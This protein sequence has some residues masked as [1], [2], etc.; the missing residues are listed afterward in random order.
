MVAE[1][2]LTPSQEPEAACAVP[3]NIDAEQAILG[4]LLYENA[5]YHRIADWLKSEHFHDPVHARIFEAIGDQIGIGN[6]C[7]PI[8]LKAKLE[9]DDGLVQIGGTAYLVELVQSAPLTSNAAVEYGR[10]V[11]ELALRRALIRVSDEMGYAARRDSDD[12]AAELIEE[13]EA[14]LAALTDTEEG[15]T[16]CSAGQALRAALD[17][18]LTFIETGLSGFDDMRTIAPAL[19][20]VGARSSM[21]KSAIV[22]DQVLRSARNG[23]PS[24]MLTN[25]MTARQIAAR[26]AASMTGVPYFAITNGTMHQDQRDQVAQCIAEIEALPITIIECPGSGIP[27]LRSRIRRWLRKIEKAG[28]EPGVVGLDYLQNISGQGGSLYERTSDIALGLQTVQLTFGICLL[29]ACQLARAAEHEK[30]KRPSIR[31]LRDSGK[32]EEVADKILLVY[33]DSYYA[34][35]E[36]EEA[37][38]IKEQERRER[39][40]SR[41]VEVDLAKNRLGPL[42]KIKLVGDM[43]CNRFEDW[44]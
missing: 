1:I 11:A 12:P 7:D 3:S 20:V 34:E 5:T 44:T 6:L 36:P 28:H 8:T 38:A 41:L 27:G 39:A 4:A 33:R 21:G 37:D 40:A 14:S 15:E 10:I 31:H 42:G 22:A 23:K 25:E 35:R 18:P 16:E 30:D 43:A 19:I 29:V 26:W 17:Q 13:A 2:A 32:I 24:L 9:R